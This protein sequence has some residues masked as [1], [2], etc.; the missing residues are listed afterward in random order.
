MNIIVSVKTAK[1]LATLKSLGIS[2]IMINDETFSSGIKGL[3]KDSLANMVSLIHGE[4]LKCV[5]KCDML[6]DERNLDSLKDYLVFLNELKVDAVLFSDITIKVLVD[7]NNLNLQTIYAPETLLTNKYDVEVLKQDDFS[8]CVI[9]KDIPLS[10]AYDIV[11]YINDYCYIRVHGE[12]LISYSKRRFISAYYG[13]DKEY[14]DRYYFVEESRENKMPVVERRDGFWMYGYT[15]ESLSQ[16][17]TIA[18]LPFRGVIIDNILEDDDYSLEVVKLYMAVLNK[19]ISEDEAFEKLS[20]LNEN[21]VYMGI[22][23]IKRTCLK[24]E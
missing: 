8:N 12:I 15:L 10:D 1:N 14:I 4:N 2:H 9:S 17:S 19:E 11:N 7:Q 18:S 6:Y 24:K 22:D 21:V 16:I 20:S 13:E 3:D 5:V 23:D